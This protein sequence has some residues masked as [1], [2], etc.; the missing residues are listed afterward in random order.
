MKR[1]AERRAVTAGD[2]DLLTLYCSTWE[3]SANRG[4]LLREGTICRLS[5]RLAANRRTIVEKPNLNLRIAE[6]AEKS[7]LS[8]LTR[9]GLDSEGPR[10]GKAN[11]AAEAKI[12]PLTRTLRQGSN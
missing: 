8:I 6:V 7:M 10:I 4:D 5:Q 1:L 12:S 11:A 9:S 2:A 3:R